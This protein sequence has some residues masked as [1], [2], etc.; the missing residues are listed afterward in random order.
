[1]GIRPH[2]SLL[3]RTASKQGNPNGWVNCLE[4]IPC[5]DLPLGTKTWKQFHH[6]QAKERRICPGHHGTGKLER[7][8]VFETFGSWRKCWSPY[9][10]ISNKHQE[11]LKKCLGSPWHVA[12]LFHG[13]LFYP[14]G[15]CRS[16]LTSHHNRKSFASIFGW[17]FPSWG[18][19]LLV[20]STSRC[21][22]SM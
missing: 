17:V 5:D 7:E 12:I 3:P 8:V 22:V 14:F 1:M 18:I 15:F 9:Q 19:E 20:R 4:G 16:E 2:I 21:V 13:R 10:A 11:G 6:L